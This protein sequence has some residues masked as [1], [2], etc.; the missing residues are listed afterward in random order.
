[1][2]QSD[3]GSRRTVQKT[4]AFALLSLWLL[5]G[6]AVQ[7]AYDNVDRLSRWFVSDY[8]VLTDPQRRVF[9]QGVLDIW[10]WHRGAHLPRYADFLEALRTS[11]KDGTD[12][13]EIESVV[14]TVIGWAEEIEARALP[15]AINLLA[16]LSDEQVAELRRRLAA[17]NAELAE[18]ELGESIEM[19]QRRWQREMKSRMTRFVGRLTDAQV[20]YIAAQSVRYV[21]ERVLWSEYRSRWQADLLQLLAERADATRFD[22]GFRR[23]AASREAYYGAE[24]TAIWA[25]NRALSTE[26]TVWLFNDLNNSQRQRMDERLRELALELRELVPQAL[27]EGGA[28]ADSSGCNGVTTC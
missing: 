28:P 2:N 10:N 3:P 21:P 9:D 11:L 5:S 18:D 25:R 1:M 14:N 24:L 19:S 4:L 27:P 20:D 15:V 26:V 13:A 16:S 12:T 8:I 17:D 7:L 22:T 6:C 23:L